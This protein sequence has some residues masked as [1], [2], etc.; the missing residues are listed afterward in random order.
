VEEDG[1]L[2][3]GEAGAEVA[4]GHALRT[5]RDDTLQTEEQGFGQHPPPLFCTHDDRREP[6]TSASEVTARGDRANDRRASHV[7]EI[8]V[9]NKPRNQFF[10]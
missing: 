8:L 6:P 1:E 2:A 7:S 10:M 3:P 5:G 4:C 9:L